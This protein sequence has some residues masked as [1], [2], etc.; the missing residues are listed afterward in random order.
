M[1]S[2]PDAYRAFLEA[3][4]KLAPQIGF[5]VD[6]SEVNPDLRPHVRAIVPWALAGG[7]RAIFARFGL[8]KTTM[9]IE[10]ARL[11]RRHV[12]GEA[13]IVLPLGVRQEF[14]RDAVERFKGE[15]A[16]D[17]RFIR[18]PEE[19]D[20]DAPVNRVYLTNY[21]TIRDGKLDPRLFTF[22]SLAEASVLRGFGGSKTFREFMRLFET[23]RFRFVA[24]ATPSPNEHIELLAYAAYLDIMDVGQA[25]T[26]FFKRDSEKADQ[27]VIHP[28]K[29]R[30]F[31]L[32]VS[33]WALFIQKPSDLGFSDEGYVLPPLDLRWHEVPTDMASVGEERDGQ[34]RM[35]PTAAIGVSDAAREKRDSLRSRIAKLVEIRAEDPGAHRLIWHDL[36]AERHAIEKA[37]PGIVS[38]YGAQDLEEREKSIIDFSDGA[39][40]ELAAKP[41]IAGSGCNFQRHCSWAVFLGIGFKFNDFI[42]A[43]HRI[44]RFGQARR[45]RIDIITTEAE[46][47]V[48]RRLE[49]RWAQHEELAKEMSE[50]IREYGLSNAAL[51]ETLARSIGTSRV[52]ISDAEAGAGAEWLYRL[53]NDDCVEETR[54]MPADGVDLIVTSIPFSTQYEYTPSY[55]DFGHTDDD[56]HFWAQMD[57]LIPEILRVTRPGRVAAV[58]VKDRITPGGINGL[59]F[60]TVSPFSDDCVAAFRRHGWAFLA[61]KTVVTDVVREN[62][63]TYR[64]GWTSSAR[65]GRGWAA[66]CRNTCCS[67]GSLRPISPT[68]T[69]T[70]QS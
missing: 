52:E 40:P 35:F 17:L 12:G 23:V 45:C 28:H 53:V 4:I 16:V 49:R 25:K 8:H 9:Q 3:K 10:M 65:T 50:I 63:Q 31:W 2:P 48:R 43:I 11:A 39:F 19:I 5:T 37:I 64:L 54:R 20:P 6:P 14:F 66:A 61:R 42:Q 33:S 59:G 30:E 32:W 47:D 24:T 55:N 15:Y 67:S 26:R 57:F 68:A 56:A 69:P 29:V 7:R 21:E 70:R 44:V 27:L 62:N 60:Q 1:T 58:H 51:A 41:V 18:R 38:V 22:A 13:L 34:G 36:E 46:R